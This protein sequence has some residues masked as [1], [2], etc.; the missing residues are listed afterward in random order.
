VYLGP[1]ILAFRRPNVSGDLLAAV[2]SPFRM[3]ELEKV[4][5]VPPRVRGGG[6]PE[7]GDFQGFA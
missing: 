6:D 3:M 1:H 2:P 4:A 5:H 7:L